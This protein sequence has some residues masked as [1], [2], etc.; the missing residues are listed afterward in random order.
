MNSICRCVAAAALVGAVG[1]ATGCAPVAIDA[2]RVDETY[3]CRYMTQ[4]C[5]ESR[6]F[7]AK[8]AKM[9]QEE[10]REMETVLQAYRSQCGMAM[11]ACKKSQ[12]KLR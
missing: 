2:S 8:Y 11:E 5:A 9:S 1:L 4:I 6:D 10:Q 12:R 7:E 3:Q